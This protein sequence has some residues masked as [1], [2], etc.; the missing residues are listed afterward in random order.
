[1]LIQHPNQITSWYDYVILYPDLLDILIYKSGPKKE[2]KPKTVLSAFWKEMRTVVK[3]I[4][5]SIRQT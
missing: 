2:A 5:F 4:N 3:N 1:M